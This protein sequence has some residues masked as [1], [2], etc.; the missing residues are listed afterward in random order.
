MKT[1]LKELQKEIL[2]G[3][4]LGQGHLL[5]IN[6][7]KT[8]RLKIEQSVKHKDYVFHLYDIWKEF[9]LTSPTI[10]KND[11]RLYYTFQTISLSSFRFYAQLFYDVKGK[12]I[13]P[14]ESLLLKLLTPLGLAY[15]FMDDGSLKSLQ[16]KGVFLNTQGFTVA[17][18]KTLSRVLKKKFSL[19]AWKS[20][21]KTGFRIYISGKSYEKLRNLIFPYLQES[22]YYKFPTPRRKDIKIDQTNLL[23]FNKK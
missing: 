14:R 10:I 15:W 16:S 9:C 22:F 19:D 5:T 2:I 8:F 23:S 11:S 18:I 12:K 1:K 3:I 7:G 13:I 20:K 17:E 6:K 4:I 21:D